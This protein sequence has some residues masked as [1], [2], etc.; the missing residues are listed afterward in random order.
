MLGIAAV[1]SIAGGLSKVMDP[2]TADVLGSLVFGVGFVM[3]TIGR[4]ELFTENFMIPFAAAF[5]RRAKTV[6]LARLYAIA[7]VANLVAV[8]LLAWMLSVERVLDHGSLEAAGRLADT[9]A[10]RSVGP[11][12]LS[13]VIA[14][15]LVTLWTWMSEAADSAGG[16]IAI[17]FLVGLVLSVAS[18]NHVIV[19]TGTM[20]FGKLSDTGSITQWSDIYRNFAVAIVGNVIGGFGLVTLTRVVQARGEGGEIRAMTFV[21]GALFWFAAWFASA[22]LWLVLT[23]SVRIEELVA[24]AV[25]AALAATGFERARR[26]RVAAQALRPAFAKR[27]W[28][29]LLGA[30]IDVGRLT[31]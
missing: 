29:V 11:A 17:A 4:G 3:I 10:G 20:I 19:V 8:A 1:V 13:A 28:R 7:L 22:L 14:G 31:R 30:V 27:V 21:R 5:A 26:E 9:Y 6:Q 18:L 16:R 25:V 12:F 24:G 2:Q 15:A 23:D